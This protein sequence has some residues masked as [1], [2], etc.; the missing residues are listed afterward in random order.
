[1]WRWWKWQAV[2]LQRKQVNFDVGFFIPSERERNKIRIQRGLCVDEEQYGCVESAE[3]IIILSF[4]SWSGYIENNYLYFIRLGNKSIRILFRFPF[5]LLSRWI[6]F[7]ISQTLCRCTYTEI[8][9]N[10]SEVISLLLYHSL[11][12]LR[13]KDR[14][15]N[16]S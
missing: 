7:R 9:A 4:E 3:K 15:N 1:M 10:D 5:V 8:F 12:V 11:F 6:R 14:Q 2:A 16:D 13:A